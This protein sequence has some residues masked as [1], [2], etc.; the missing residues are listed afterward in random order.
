LPEVRKPLMQPQTEIFD[1]P[2]FHDTR[3]AIYGAYYTQKSR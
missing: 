3:Q 1:A 2:S